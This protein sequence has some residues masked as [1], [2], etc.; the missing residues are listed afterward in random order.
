MP[1]G[2]PT[3][4]ASAEVCG[5]APVLALRFQRLLITP[6]APASA[7]LLTY[8]DQAT[9]L[10][11]TG[12]SDATG[13]LPALGERD[14]A[15]TPGSSATTVGA[16]TFHATRW[17]MG[18]VSG[19]VGSDWTTRLP[20][21][22]IAISVG[23]GGSA[24]DSIDISFVSAV[25]A[26]GFD[27]SEPSLGG[28]VQNGCY[29]PCVDSTFEVTLENGNTTVG[30]F[31]FNVVDDTAA[32]VGVWSSLP[33]TSLEVREI[34]GRDDNEYYGRVYTGN[35][36]AVAEPAALALVPALAGLAAVG[37]P[38]RRTPRES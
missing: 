10:A 34:V 5:S 1:D 2:S 31:Q 3:R 14:D 18:A 8:D 27:F 17:F 11:A 32:F 19:V 23:P 29:L 15:V 21:V 22:D 28:A 7:T 37:K 33:F 24:D 4:S 12:A 26:A 20:G 25:Y 30:S 38:R 16:V 6:S 35:T 13:A 36:P 9:F